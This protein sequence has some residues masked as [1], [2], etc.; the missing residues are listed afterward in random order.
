MTDLGMNARAWQIAETAIGRAAELRAAIL[1][2]AGGA[3]VLDLGVEVPGGFGAGRLLAELC[4]G[5]LGHVEI[6]SVIIDNDT[7]PGV[8][9]WTDHPAESC[10]ASQYA[11]WAINPA[12][13]FAMGSGPLRAKARVE[14]ELF[15]KLQY[16]EQ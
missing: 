12:G 7:W 15:E 13:F 14:L 8:H 2:L 5:G 1:T 4:M 16:V 10:M 11:G 9:V 3:R 6:G